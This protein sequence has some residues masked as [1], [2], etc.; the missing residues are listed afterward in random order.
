[1]PDIK[2]QKNID[3]I[4]VFQAFCLTLYVL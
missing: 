4:K 3:F 2:N 1:M